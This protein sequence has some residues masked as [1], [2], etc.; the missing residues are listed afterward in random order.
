MDTKGRSRWV[1][2]TALVVVLL[3]SKQVVLSR[4]L[5]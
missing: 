5:P 3:V 2:R 4:E 1:L